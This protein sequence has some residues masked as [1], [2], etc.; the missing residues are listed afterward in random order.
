MLEDGWLMFGNH[1][2]ED[3]GAIIHREGI[4]DSSF[5]TCLLA[6]T[7]VVGFFTIADPHGGGARPQTP[8]IV[9]IIFSTGLRMFAYT[10]DLK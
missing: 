1:C 6:C 4:D 9:A 2:I 3:I 8:R 7:R 10:M 5:I